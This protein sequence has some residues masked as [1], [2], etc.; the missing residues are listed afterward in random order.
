MSDFLRL[1]TSDLY[2]GVI[3]AVLAV[4]LGALQQAV[5]AHGLD[6][7]TYDWGSIF[8]L[9]ITAGVAYLGKNFATNQDGKFFGV[10]PK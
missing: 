3:V 1:G 10:G 7:A 4:V 8:Q 5:T 9:A 2:K 6:F